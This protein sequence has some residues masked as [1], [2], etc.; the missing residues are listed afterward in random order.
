M[1][2]ELNIDVPS[3][4]NPSSCTS[5]IC[6]PA[7]FFLHIYSACVC[8]SVCACRSSATTTSCTW[9]QWARRTPASMCARPSCPGSAWE[10]PR[11]RSLS[12]VGGSQFTSSLFFQ[13]ENVSS[14]TLGI[15]SSR[16]PRL[17][18]LLPKDEEQIQTGRRHLFGGLITT[19]MSVKW[20]AENGW[21]DESRPKPKL[22]PFTAGGASWDNYTGPLERERCNI[23]F[24]HH[25]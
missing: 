5:H 19:I 2:N 11:S 12:T 23:R 9:S 16:A 7:Y 1:F 13:A 6:H 15:I 3:L 21:R 22:R 8:I 24:H 14:A 17:L 10:R 18:L 20:A 4:E 25:M